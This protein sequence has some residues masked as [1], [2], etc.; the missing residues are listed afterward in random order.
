[1]LT[2]LLSGLW[3]GNHEDAYN[4]EFYKDNLI[5][6]TINCTIDKSFCNVQNV[7]NVRVPVS[8][9]TTT[10]D[11]LHLQTNMDKIIKFIHENIEDH[12]ILLFGYNNYTVP[13]IIVGTYMK[14]IGDIPIHTIKDILLS[15][16]NTIQ[17][18]TDIS[19]FV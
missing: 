17:L 9:Q 11:I 13:S 2:E 5:S 15:K 18:D 12:N 6:M 8:S 1:M 16:N 3:I 4:N 7:K 14:K 10:E 19:L